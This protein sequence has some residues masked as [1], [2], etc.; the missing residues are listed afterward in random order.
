MVSCNQSPDPGQ[1]AL[2]QEID[3][4]R[5]Q[6]MNAYSPGLGEF[7]TSIQ[8]HHAKLWFAGKSCNWGLANFEMEEIQES[9]DDIEKYCADR[10]EIH[11]LPMIRPSLDSIRLSI[12]KKDV[13]GFKSSFIQLT[14]TCNQCHSAS[15][16]AFNVIK[17]PDSP[18]V[19]NQ[20]FEPV[21]N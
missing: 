17:I 7:M 2:Q 13:T 10:P 12:S 6:T 11:L 15:K 18:P 8:L 9:L 5:R 1:S 20:V 14:N 19:S 16:H 4:L 3:S 21:K